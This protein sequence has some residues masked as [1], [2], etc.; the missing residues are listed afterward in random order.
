MS[1]L[2]EDA[3]ESRRN[4]MMDRARQ[5]M[6]AGIE[7]SQK[8]TSSPTRAGAGSPTPPTPAAA[9]KVVRPPPDPAIEVLEDAN[10]RIHDSWIY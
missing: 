6:Q 4:K 9:P 8:V 7:D 2:A 10:V 3:D 5:Y 1:S